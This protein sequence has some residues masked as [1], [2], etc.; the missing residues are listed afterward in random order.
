VH[1]WGGDVEI[2]E[3]VETGNERRRRSNIELE[4]YS[5][6]KYAQSLGVLVEVWGV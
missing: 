2:S 4:F 3:Y 5:A 6:W 1:T